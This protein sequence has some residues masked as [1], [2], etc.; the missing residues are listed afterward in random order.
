MNEEN[1]DKLFSDFPRLFSGRHLSMQ[2]NLM[3]FGFSCDDGWFD[4]IYSLSKDLEAEYQKLN[5]TKENEEKYIVF[6]VKE[7]F[8][9]LR[10]YMDSQTEEMSRLIEIA[11]DASFKICEICGEPGRPRKKGSNAYGWIKTVCETHAKEW[12]EEGQR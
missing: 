3:C 6:Q 7:K 12:L 8:G 1:T 11:E 2:H 10:F 4:L 5:I 9:G